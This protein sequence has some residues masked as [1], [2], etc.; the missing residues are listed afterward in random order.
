[1]LIELTNE[2]MEKFWVNTIN[3]KTVR[4]LMGGKSQIDFSSGS[5]VVCMES[6]DVVSEKVNKALLIAKSFNEENGEQH[7]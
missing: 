1:M 4:P 2:R 6:G 3:I 5:Y 7:A